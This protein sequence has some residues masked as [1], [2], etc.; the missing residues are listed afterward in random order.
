MM[1]MMMM[2]T[3]TTTT[4]T[5][6]VLMT[7]PMT[8]THDEDDDDAPKTPTHDD[9]G[10]EPA[11]LDDENVSM[12]ATK[13]TKAT[14]AMKAMT[15]SV[16]YRCVALTVGLKPKNVKA[17][18]EAMMTVA[19]QQLGSAGKFKVADAF[20]MRLKKTS[21]AKS[22]QTVLARPTKKFMRRI[23]MAAMNATKAN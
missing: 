5:T 15:P 4:T 1:M 17:V 20:N 10:D 13:A 3:T 9:D 7:T 2:K 8:P 23:E 11:M 12:K 19:A 6:A 18:A 22:G 14:K 16:S 21:K